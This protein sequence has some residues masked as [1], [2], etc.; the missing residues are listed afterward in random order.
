MWFT[1]VMMILGISVITLAITYFL[2]RK[3][4]YWIPALSLL[5]LGLIMIGLSQLDGIKDNWSSTILVVFGMIFVFSFILTA[6]TLFFLH[7]SKNRK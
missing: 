7:M 3:K 6:I 4:R 2:P 5:G 1:I